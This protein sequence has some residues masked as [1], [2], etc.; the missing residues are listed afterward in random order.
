MA[1]AFWF[2][3]TSAMRRLYLQPPERKPSDEARARARHA[4]ELPTLPEA[5]TPIR[6]DRGAPARTL[7]RASRG[8][9]SRARFR[10]RAETTRRGIRRPGRRVRIVTS[11]IS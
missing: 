7:T 8:R 9:S 4:F 10:D 2:G 3:S 5:L 11:E 6:L 1:T